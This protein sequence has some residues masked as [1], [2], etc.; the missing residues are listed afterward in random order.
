M[1]NDGKKFVG[2]KFNIPFFLPQGGNAHIVKLPFAKRDLDQVQNLSKD[3]DSALQ[4]SDRATVYNRAVN[5]YITHYFPEYYVYLYD[6]DRFST[7]GGANVDVAQRLLQTVREKIRIDRIFQ[8]ANQGTLAFVVRLTMNIDEE[9]NRLKGAH[10]LPSFEETLAF[11][12]EQQKI[13]DVTSEATFAI[14]T[15]GSVN[16]ALNDGL[17]SFNDQMRGMEGQLSLNPNM[18]MLANTTQSALSLAINLLTQQLKV[19]APSYNFGEADSMTIYFGTQEVRE[20]FQPRSKI[21]IGRIEYVVVEDSISPKTM[22]VGYFSNVKYNQTVKDPLTLITLKN[23]QT[24][25]DAINIPEG[26]AAPGGFMSFITNPEV[27][28]ALTPNAALAGGTLAEQRAFLSGSGTTSVFQPNSPLQRINQEGNPFVNAARALGGIDITNTKELE[29]GFKTAFNSEELKALKVQIADNPKVFSQVSVAQT[30]KNLQKAIDTVA[31]L[32]NIAETGPFGFIEKNPAVNNLFKMF[33]I[34]ELAKEALLCLTMGLNFEIGRLTGAVKNSLTQAQASLYEPPIIPRQGGDIRKPYINPDDFKMFTIDGDIWKQVL[35]VVIDALQQTVLEII[36]KL[37]DLLKYN[38]PLNNPRAEDYGATSIPDLIAPDSNLPILTGPGSSL[39]QIAVDLGLSTAEMIEYLRDISSILSSME[40]CQL[41]TQRASVGPDLLDK[42]IEFNQTYSHPYFKE[43]GTEYSR[44]LAFFEKVSFIIDVTDLCNDVANEIFVANQENINLCLT[45][46]QLPTVDAQE[47]IELME[48]GIDLKMPALNFDCPDK[49]N[50][51]RDPTITTS[52]PEMFNTLTNLV[53]AQFVE[54]AEATKKVLL[55]ET[56]TTDAGGSILDILNSGLSDPPLG[57]Q[58]ADQGWPPKL[59]PA[60][61]GAIIGAMEKIT[62]MTNLESCDIDISQV[63]GFD[64]ASVAGIAGDVTQVVT[65]TLQDPGFG[66]AIDEIVAQLQGLQS[67]DGEGNE[68]GLPVFPSYRFNLQFYREFV[69]Y[70]DFSERGTVVLPSQTVVDVPTYF[71][72]FSVDDASPFSGSLPPRGS[73]LRITD[74]S[75]NPLKLVFAFPSLPGQQMSLQ[76]RAENARLEPAPDCLNQTQIDQI[77]GM[78]GTVPVGRG[79]P[80]TTHGPM[81]AG[82][83]YHPHTTGDDYTIH[84]NDGI[85]AGIDGE[86]DGMH[87]TDG[88]Y[89]PDHVHPVATSLGPATAGTDSEEVLDLVPLPY[90]RLEMEYPRENAANPNIYI[91]FKSLGGYIP[92]DELIEQIKESEEEQGY[93]LSSDTNGQNIYVKKFTDAFS[94]ETKGGAARY[95]DPETKKRHIEQTHFPLAHSL[96]VDRMFDYIIRNGVFDAATLQSL[97]FFHDNQNCPP[98]EIADLLDLGKG[99]G[100]FPGGILGQMQKEYV[101]SMCNDGPDPDA[102]PGTPRAIGIPVRKRVRNIVIYGMY[103]LL[104]QMHIAQFFIKNIFVMSAFQI[105]TLMDNKDSFIFKFLRQQITQTMLRFLT[106]ADA[107][108]E[109]LARQS[110][111]SYFNLKINR[112]SVIAQGGIRNALGDLVFPAGIV[113][114][115]VD[116]GPFVGFD[117]IIDFLISERLIIGAQSVANAITKA[118]PDGN[119]VALDEAFL[120]SL[121]A[122]TVAEDTTAFITPKVKAYYGDDQTPQLFIT[123][124]YMTLINGVTR[125]RI[126][127]WYY[128]SDDTLSPT[129]SAVMLFALPKAISGFG[130]PDSS[131][132]MATELRNQ[133][134]KGSSNS[135]AQNTQSTS[136]MGIG[137]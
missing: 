67:V 92:A 133:I 55:Q 7:L 43:N 39:D 99:G 132:V 104:I 134:S 116:D 61:L 113:F 54:S 44:V 106:T 122:F 70:I 4:A 49:E 118:R 53:E 59:D 119:P 83:H 65:D 1:A 58:Y 115:V 18:G 50:F 56:F 124:K 9:R 89:I 93:E 20:A 60:I 69:N 71:R 102:A 111:V 130:Q 79:C 64:A 125:A 13:S 114:S 25:L 82:E 87:S 77:L 96:M 80:G 17:Q 46:D 21:A 27:Q 109:S 45:P 84:Q 105:E 26:P 63:L 78:G 37:A 95:E 128:Y 52:I 107:M 110:L 136:T 38:C 42:I 48:N 16:T 72:S 14:G 31:V 121:P 112:R 10:C 137:N 129:Q 2:K 41:F 33:G 62:T 30:K 22:K 97:T 126:K 8:P 127:L 36:K 88:T 57:E 5:R 15:I 19:S 86:D 120:T 3:G 66:Q 47:L 108:D 35:D 74:G 28:M 94:F 32:E 34:K 23:Y 75:Y 91:N 117:E 76:Q 6:R 85:V 73:P 68:V 100:L 40:I 51:L 29:K 123:R 24:I 12:N 98:P 135:S 103:L 81:N 101:E 11:F 131:A 90:N